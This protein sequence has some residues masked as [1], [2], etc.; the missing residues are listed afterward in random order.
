MHAHFTTSTPSLRYI[1]RAGDGTPIVFLHGVCRAAEDFEPLFSRLPSDWRLI[2]IDHRGHGESGRADRYLVV[3]YVADATWFLRETVGRPAI[4]HG[5]SL[6]AMT[7]AAVASQAP[8]LVKGI[9]LEDPPFHTMGRNIV[10]TSWHPLFSGMREAATKFSKGDI[11]AAIAE[12]RL[13]QRD[14]SSKRLG[15]LRSLESIL[16]SARCLTRLDPAVLTP[17][18]ESRW[19]DEYDV[20]VMLASIRCPTLI[21]QG[22]PAAGG[23]LTDADAQ[24]ASEIIASCTIERFTGYGHQL[25]WD[26][27]DKVAERVIAFV[28]SIES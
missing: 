8:E 7:A 24:L 28:K 25:H 12:I 10:K 20:R 16:W 13:P 11:G 26:Q 21:L 6:G 4:L 14:G 19:L 23:T 2:S 5:H 3:D 9:V 18:V 27:P 22:D 15:E 17:I 1:D